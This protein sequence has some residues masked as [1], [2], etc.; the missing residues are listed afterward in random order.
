MNEAGQ[1]RESFAAFML[2]MRAR[3]IGGKELFAAMEAT[4]RAGFLPS[5][6]Y[7]AA[8]SQRMVPIMAPRRDPALMMVR[9]MASQT[10]MNES[11]PE[12]SA[13]TP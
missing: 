12:A 4:P 3:G 8:W 13:P 11:G 1:E 5:E 9:H 7:A 6:W 10:S 2:R